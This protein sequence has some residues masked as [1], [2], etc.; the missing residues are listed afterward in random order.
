M[1]EPGVTDE[2]GYL[3]GPIEAAVRTR[4]WGDPVDHIA[5]EIADEVM[6]GLEQVGAQVVRLHELGPREEE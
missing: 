2:S 4:F 3:R 6:R 5:A 1:P